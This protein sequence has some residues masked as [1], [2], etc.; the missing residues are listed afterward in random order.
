MAEH[1]TV[2]QALKKLEQIAEEW[3]ERD[4]EKGIPLAFRYWPGGHY[5][6]SLALILWKSILVPFIF[7]LVVFTYAMMEEWKVFI[8]LLACYVIYWIIGALLSR[9]ENGNFILKMDGITVVTPRKKIYIPWDAVTDVCS[10][11]SESVESIESK[12]FHQYQAKYGNAYELVILT[13]NKCYSFYE[14]YATALVKDADGQISPAM[15]PL[16]IAY[17]VIKAAHGKVKNN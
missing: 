6:E 10:S 7:G 4:L 12:G 17:Q 8:I 5:K 2:G 3:V 15:M 9:R 16:H 13:P 1:I 11:L 14:V